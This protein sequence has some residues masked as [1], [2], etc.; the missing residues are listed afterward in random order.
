MYW[1]NTSK[2]AED[3]SEG[4]VDEKERVKY[5]LATFAALSIIVPVFF[6]SVGPLSIDDL[7]YLLVS[8]IIGVI[9]IFLCYRANRSGDNIDF[10]PRMICLNWTGICGF[11]TG[12]LFLFVIHTLAQTIQGFSLVPFSVFGSLTQLVRESWSFWGSF[13]SMSTWVALYYGFIY[14]NLV[15]S[16]QAKEGRILIE[17]VTTDLTLAKAL[18]G[19]LMLLGS[20]FIYVAT[21][22]YVTK[23]AGAE[24][25]A[26]LV[27]FAVTA[28]LLILLGWMFALLHKRAVKR[29]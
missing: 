28:L 21:Q 3:L 29:S 17:M 8:A 26:R 12:Y 23:P 15:R 14:Y 10:I 22:I 19:I 24:I 1:L 27:G 2:L 5:Y 4:R 25:I 13:P 9:G 18:L 11:L 6:Y 20:A 16:P 7:V